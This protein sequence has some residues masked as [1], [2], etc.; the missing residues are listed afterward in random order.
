MVM[1]QPLQ[2]IRFKFDRANENIINLKKELDA[3]LDRNP[4]IVTEE[5]D[6]AAKKPFFKVQEKPERFPEL[7]RFSVLVGEIT[8]HLRSSLVII[9]SLPVAVLTA[10]I[11][12]Y[13]QGLNANIMSLG[14]IAIAIGA[15]VDGAIV[16][17]ENMHKHMERHSASGVD[18]WQLVADSACEVG[19][20]LFFSLLIITV[21]F[22]PIF[23]L[24]AAPDRAV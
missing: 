1:P 24:E 13:F 17:V 9:I 3:F 23:T 5:K 11:L 6:V 22:M 18:R 10:V 8:H 4:H 7:L 20:A 21:S 2:D 12:M 15:M 16:L 19:P 14:G